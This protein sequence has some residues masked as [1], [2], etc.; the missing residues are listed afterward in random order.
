MVPR[1]TSA[2]TGVLASVG[3]TAATRVRRF[4]CRSCT[5][6]FGNDNRPASPVWRGWVTAL[7]G[8]LA[9]G[10]LLSCVRPSRFPSGH[11]DAGSPLTVAC[12]CD[13]A[14]PA[15]WRAAQLTRITPPP[16]NAVAESA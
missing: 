9:R 15:A 5:H 10:S 4:G 11:A 6:P 12:E 1:I 3:K 16:P 7:A 13:Y 8:L 14:P 2:Q